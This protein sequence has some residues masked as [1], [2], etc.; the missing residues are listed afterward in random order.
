MMRRLIALTALLVV[1]SPALSSAHAPSPSRTGRLFLPLVGRG[2]TNVPLADMVLIPAG[3]F[4]MGCDAS[5]PNE[6]CNNE[7]KPLH[8]VQLS[9]YYID[10]TEVTNAQYAQCVAAGVC[11]APTSSGSLNRPSYYGNPLYRDY[12]VV[13]V[14]WARARDYCAWAG[15]RLP[16]EAQWEKAARGSSDTRVYPWGNRAADCSLAN[17]FNGYYCTGETTRVGSCPDGASPYGALDMAGNVWEWVVDW[18]A[19]AYYS[20]SPYSNPTGPATGELKVARGGS[21][22]GQPYDLRVAARMPSDVNYASFG[23]GF[24]CVAPVPGG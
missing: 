1:L 22:H 18:F 13:Y 20:A 15:K 10:K 21:W 7:E 24:R 11:S 2:F 17:F 9:G 23:L 4:Q 14:D 8:T 6:T 12:P 19:Y 16:T 3:V 5:N